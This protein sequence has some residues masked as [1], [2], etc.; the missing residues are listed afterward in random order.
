M[1]LPRA[2]SFP[3]AL[4]LVD[5]LTQYVLIEPLK[6]KTAENVKIALEKIIEENDLIKINTIS[7]D[8]GT[9]FTANI[10]HFK[11]KGIKWFLLKSDVKASLAELSIRIFKSYLY[12]M[13]RLKPG[14][15]WINVYKKVRDQMNMRSIKSL[16]GHSPAELFSPF[17]DVSKTKKLQTK[18]ETR[19]M[20]TTGPIFKINDLVFLD[21]KR[22]VNDKGYDIQRGAIKRVTHID[23]SSKPYVYTLDHLD[24]NKHLPRPYYGAELRKAPKLRAL[25]KQ[26]DKIY[27][28]RR[29]N[30]K[31]EYL[32]SFY[33]SDYKSWIPE[34]LLYKF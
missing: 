19:R 7:S 34:R 28:S 9:E 16:N 2:R 12:K 11:K 10:S 5:L 6:K 30:K 26:I 15:M 14:T 24:S 18:Q 29:K 20:Q 22:N 21:I 13:L 4:I 17:T 27:E 25:P 3:Y 31:R 8:S 32:V 33:G 1:Y 23:K